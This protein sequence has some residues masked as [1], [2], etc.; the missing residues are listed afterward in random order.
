MY[1]QDR[2]RL[3]YVGVETERFSAYLPMV[4]LIPQNYIVL[5]IP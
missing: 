1:I 3:I 2:A 5:S 4:L